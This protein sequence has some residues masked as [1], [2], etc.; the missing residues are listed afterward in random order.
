[1]AASTKAQEIAH[2]ARER[3]EA[4]LE[5]AR[6]ALDAAKGAV[7]DGLDDTHRY[8]KRQWRERPI[9]VAAAVGVGLLVGCCR[10]PPLMLIAP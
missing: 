1:M 8:L 10:Q 2:E 7:G 5:S 3:A 9:T 6:E 4:A